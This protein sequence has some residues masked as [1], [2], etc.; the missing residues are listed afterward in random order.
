[1]KEEIRALVAERDYVSF[2][3]LSRDITGFVG[4][5]GWE[6]R[7]KNIF[8]WTGLSEK[9]FDAIFELLESEEV[10]FE[11]A[12]FMSYAIDGI[13]QNMPLAKSLKKPYKKP[14]WLP[15]TLRPGKGVKGKA[16][17]VKRDDMTNVA[18]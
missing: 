13:T 9:A 3:E 7:D 12:S 18:S 10:H 11:P 1:L 15:V 14:H 16:L 5:I 4:N 17:L 8:L 6:L 2:A